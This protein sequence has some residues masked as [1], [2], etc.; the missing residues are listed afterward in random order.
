[1]LSNHKYCYFDWKTIEF[2][3]TS[4]FDDPTTILFTRIVRKLRYWL[5]QSY[6][7]GGISHFG[8]TQASACASKPPTY[9]TQTVT[10]LNA[11]L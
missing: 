10:W 1:V 2:F 5:E 4:I 3:F 8:S 9:A 6:S 11:K 7:K